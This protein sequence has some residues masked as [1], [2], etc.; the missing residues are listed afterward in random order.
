MATQEQ[1]QA[2]DARMRD[3]LDAGDL[4]QPDQ[5]EYREDEVVFMWNEPKAAVVLEVTGESLDA[6]RPA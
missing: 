6:S 2:A 1:L 5:V 3:L 4:P